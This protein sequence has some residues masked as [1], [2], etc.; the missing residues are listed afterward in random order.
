MELLLVFY[1]YD[2]CTGLF[3]NSVE[4]AQHFPR[5]VHHISQRTSPPIPRSSAVR[6]VRR[7]LDVEMIA[8]PMPP[9][10]RVSMSAIG[11]VN[12]RGAYQLDFVIPGIAPWW[13]SSRRQIRQR[14]NFRN[15]DRG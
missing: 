15:T 2:S 7:P 9:R 13:A 4:S 11:S 14:P 10:M 5:L 12:I 6:A 3:L 1:R 8:V